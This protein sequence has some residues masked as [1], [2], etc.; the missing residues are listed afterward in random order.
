MKTQLDAS[1]QAISKLETQSEPE[2]TTFYNERFENSYDLNYFNYSTLFWD[3][4]IYC[5]LFQ[6]FQNQEPI[7]D[8]NEA[9]LS[10][11]EMIESFV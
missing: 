2:N 10:L 7:F 3:Q 5:P 4:N 11:E 6:D 1:L 8:Q 9:Q